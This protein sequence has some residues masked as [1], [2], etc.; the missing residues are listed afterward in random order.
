[1]CMV[2]WDSIDLVLQSASH[3]RPGGDT[4]ASFVEYLESVGEPETEHYLEH[5]SWR[6]KPARGPDDGE[7]VETADGECY[8][9]AQSAMGPSL[10][11]VEG[12]AVAD[13]GAI[14]HA[15]L[16]TDEHVVDTSPSLL[17]HDVQYF[18]VSFDH[19]TVRGSML[20][21]ETAAPIVEAV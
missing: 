8:Y 15:W 20:R 1:M 10:S 3:I 17:E 2:Q 5:G 16:E 6:D 7:P 11:Y 19:E 14:A 9:C 21:T 13:D 4:R 12:Y 18:G